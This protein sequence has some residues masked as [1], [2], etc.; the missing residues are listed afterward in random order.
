MSRQRQRVQHERAYVLHS[1]AWR[2]T[3]LLIQV[4]SQQYG[5]VSL[6]A[7]GAKRPY[8]ALRAV[9]SVFQPL[10][11]GWTGANEVKTLTQAECAG[12]HVL[13]GRAMMSV[14]YMNELLLRLL[15]KEDP[16]DVLFT[17]Y[18]QALEQ[19]AHHPKQAS[20]ALRRFEWIL[21]Q[22]T[23]YGLDQQ[24]PDFSDVEQ[25]PYLRTLLR[26]RLDE[27]LGRPLRTRGVMMDLLHL[28]S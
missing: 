3:S 17:A 2:E 26:E 16:H 1:I 27:L 6:V 7:K 28:Q 22:E 19:L 11:V 8:S 9:L 18:E 25:E 5:T 14:W 21:L 23:G 24:L 15:P 4:F 13:S 10:H 20:L 12:L